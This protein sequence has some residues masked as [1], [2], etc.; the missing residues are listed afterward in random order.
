MLNVTF[1]NPI[2]A[3]KNSNIINRNVQIIDEFRNEV[4]RDTAENL[5]ADDQI[6]K[7]VIADNNLTN[8]KTRDVHTTDK[9]NVRRSNRLTEIES[10]LI[11]MGREKNTAAFA[12]I[13]EISIEKE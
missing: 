5:S 9:F 2:D 10:S 3:M 4:A 7:D 11:R 13:D 6:F 8:S 12:A 1:E